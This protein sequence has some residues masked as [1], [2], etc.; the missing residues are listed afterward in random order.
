MFTRGLWFLA[1]EDSSMHGA[2][3]C[4]GAQTSNSWLVRVMEKGFWAAGRSRVRRLSLIHL[5]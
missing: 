5:I 1:V 4:M 2:Q 3:V